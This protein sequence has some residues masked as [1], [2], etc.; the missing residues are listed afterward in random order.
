VITKLITIAIVALSL[1]ASSSFAQSNEN[2]CDITAMADAVKACVQ[3]QGL[4]EKSCARLVAAQCLSSPGNFPSK[5]EIQLTTYY[6]TEYN[7]Y[8]KVIR[9]VDT[10]YAEDTE[11]ER[12]DKCTKIADRLAPSYEDGPILYSTATT[13]CATTAGFDP[14]EILF[15]ACL[16]L[17]R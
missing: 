5:T 7:C 15:G 12:I 1:S 2:G 3:T 13:A 9:S 16:K 4:K 17:G 14:N 11:Q 8:A 6:T 10:V